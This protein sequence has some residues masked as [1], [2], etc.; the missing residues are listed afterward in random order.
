MLCFCLS[1]EWESDPYMMSPFLP[2]FPNRSPDDFVSNDEKSRRMGNAAL[3]K[4]KKK[5]IFV[6]FYSVFIGF[7]REKGEWSS[8][9]NNSKNKILSKE[10][11]DPKFIFRTLDW[12]LAYVNNE[13][14]GF[15]DCQ[16]FMSE[17]ELTQFDK[18][19]LLIKELP[20]LKS[21]VYDLIETTNVNTIV[22][23]L[24][25]IL[26]N[27]WNSGNLQAVARD[28]AHIIQFDLKKMCDKQGLILLSKSELDAIKKDVNAIKYNDN[29]N[30]RND[31]Y[32]DSYSG[33]NDRYN[34]RFNK[35]NSQSS[36]NN[37]KVSSKVFKVIGPIRDNELHRYEMIHIDDFKGG[38]KPLIVKLSDKIKIL[39]WPA[40]CHDLNLQGYCARNSTSCKY[41]CVCTMCGSGKH[42]RIHCPM[43]GNCA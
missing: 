27:G 20:L 16:Q 6:D 40:T 38:R 9:D 24:N 34:D 8:F 15:I 32:N 30:N 10:L 22:K 39:T 19:R 1:I 35:S 41:I 28:A 23:Y 3:D 5:G 17:D 2:P 13:N 7:A 25:Y 18:N 37:A 26:V 43:R 21:K 12:L 36:S 42:G 11:D 29:Y 31:R 4:L 14:D 33:R